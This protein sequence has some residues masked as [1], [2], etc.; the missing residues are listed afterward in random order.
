MRRS[1][2]ADCQALSLQRWLSWRSRTCTTRLIGI[3]S[4]CMC[5][6]GPAGRDS[7]M[8]SQDVR[9]YKLGN[10]IPS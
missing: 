9:A 6:G 3:T 8:H 1:P 2:S 5:H 4:T 7:Q 10:S